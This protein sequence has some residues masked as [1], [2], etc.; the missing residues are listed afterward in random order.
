MNKYKLLN[1]LISLSCNLNT[2]LFYISDN[3]SRSRLKKVYA[4]LEKIKQKL[5]EEDY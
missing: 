1:D 4:E 5:K 3:E 2:A